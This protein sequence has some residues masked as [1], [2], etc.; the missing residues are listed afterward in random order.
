MIQPG[1]S[2]LNTTGATHWLGAQYQVEDMIGNEHNPVRREMEIIA[3]KAGLDFIINCVINSDLELVNVFSG[4]FIDAHRACVGSARENYSVEIDE[5]ADILIV[6]ASR[7]Q[8]N[9][10]SSASGP[11]WG[12]MT[13]KK[14]GT[15]VLLAPC[16]E[17][18]CRE[19]PE[20]LE[21]GYRSLEGARELVEK[22]LITDLAAAANIRFAG[23]KLF[24]EK[25]IKCILNSI[26]VTK[27][28]A[29]K[30]GL[31]YA[32][33]PQEA[34]NKALLHHESNCR[35]YTYPAYVFTDLII[36]SVM[37]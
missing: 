19:H 35:I 37:E 33:T 23:E 31:E 17:G 16:P 3:E 25:K 11:N 9:M 10:W 28:D 15:V 5:L 20:V 18:V 13:L 14:G 4:H 24:G 2:G 6:G 34:V 8:G 30:L 22:G 27:E 32:A 12:G 36:K 7:S 26:G 21:Y 29:G 1:I